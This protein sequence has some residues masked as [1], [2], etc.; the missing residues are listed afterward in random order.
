MTPQFLSVREDITAG[1]ALDS[2][3]IHGSEAADVGWSFVVDGNGRL[4]GGLGVLK[5]ALSRPSSL[6]SEI[7]DSQVVSVPVE[8]DREEC[9]RLMER[10]DL[11]QLAVVDGQ[12][13]L[14]GV[15]L[16]EDVVDV[17]DEEATEDIYSIAGIGGERVFGAL[18]GSVRRR[19][20]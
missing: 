6:V 8:T 7:M 1:S 9:A 14:L 11:R 16:I 2:I 17:L 20:P 18:T 19:L 15:I 5:L 13:R 3:R 10:Y 4:T 12:N